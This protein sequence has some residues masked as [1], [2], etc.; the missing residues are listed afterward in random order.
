MSRSGPF[1]Q[2]FIGLWSVSRVIS[3]HFSAST[4]TFHGTACFTAAKHGLAYIETGKLQLAGQPPF[5][6]E[7]R[8]HWHQ[9]EN[10]LHVSFDD[11]RP[12]HSFDPDNPEAS[13]WCDPDT[14]EVTYEFDDWPHWR[15]IWNVSGPR[16][17]YQMI[18]EY[19]PMRN[20]GG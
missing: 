18:T 9:D 1:L 3:D 14:Y 16:K 8:Y 12:F 19:A 11:G 5:H 7:R 17:A 13:H 4:G 10:G 2:N 6:A 15:T 20:E